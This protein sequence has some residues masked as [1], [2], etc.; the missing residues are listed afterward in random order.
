MSFFCLKTTTT[1]K[2]SSPFERKPLQEDTQ[3]LSEYSVS[4]IVLMVCVVVCVSSI[5]SIGVYMLM[6]KIR[7]REHKNFWYIRPGRLRRYVIP[8]AQRQASNNQKP[9]FQKPTDEESVYGTVIGSTATD[10]TFVFDH[11]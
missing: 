1:G 4:F 9:Y 3:N 11:L 6:K 5:F 8:K 2:P 10:E 7:S